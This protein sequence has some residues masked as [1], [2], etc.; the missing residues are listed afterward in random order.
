TDKENERILLEFGF[1]QFLQH[2]PDRIVHRREHP[3]KR[4]ASGFLDL[5]KAREILLRGL[6]WRV[7]RIEGEITKPRLGAVFF[8]K[9]YRFA[10]KCLGGLINFIDYVCPAKNLFVFICCCVVIIVCYVM[11]MYYLIKTPIDRMI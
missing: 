8:N 11:D 3:R 7:N 10:A 9:R 1:T 6:Q 4:P 2:R 5:G